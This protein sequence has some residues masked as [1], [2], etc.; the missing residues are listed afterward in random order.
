MQNKLQLFDK[1][2]FGKKAKLLLAII[3]LAI[4]ITCVVFT[5]FK[6]ISNISNSVG[7]TT[8]VKMNC[9][10]TDN[11]TNL[12]E[13]GICTDY[14]R[15]TFSD[16]CIS[17]GLREEFKIKEWRCENNS[18]VFEILPCPNNTSCVAGK[19]L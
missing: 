10:D 15:K 6:I 9:T 11:G 7:L 5:Y 14:R 19:C 18:C 17:P 8:Y 1:I 4:V 3:G 2:K 12:K 13:F 16:T